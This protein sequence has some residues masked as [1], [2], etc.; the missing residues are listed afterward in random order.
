MNKDWLIPLA[1]W[2]ASVLAMTILMGWVARSRL[3]DRPEADRHLLRHPASTLILGIVGAVLFFGAAIVSNTVGK[4]STSTIWTTLTFVGLGFASSLA[5]AD[6][7]RARHRV[8]DSGI[9]FGRMLGER[10]RLRW[11]D[12]RRVY[13]ASFLKW[14]VLEGRSGTKV[15]V[16][17]MLLGLPEFARLVLQHVPREVI[18]PD[19]L[20]LLQ[21]AEQGQLPDIDE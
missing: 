17:F 5:I 11:A 18:E 6:Y 1:Q 15:R 14:F 12:V 21:A 19:T 7:F 9:D 4:N 20:D 10:G 16:S 3:R 13:F 8:S 2:G